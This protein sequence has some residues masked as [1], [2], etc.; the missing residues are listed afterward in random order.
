LSTCS[1]TRRG[2]KE[3]FARSFRSLPRFSLRARPG[4]RFPRTEGQALVEAALA[5]PIVCAFMFTMIEAC[6]AYYS[7]CMI[8]ESAREG[9]R[10][11]IV[12]GAT[13]TTSGNASCT[14]T[15]ASINSYVTSLGWPNLGAGT[16]SASTSFPNSTE[17]PGNP[18]KVTV[19]YVFPI[20]LPFVPRNS[21][22]M[23]S[24]SEMYII[25]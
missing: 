22:S 2:I 11:A 4:S 13:C 5:L 23:S 3:L 21:I 20:N 12:H 9:T 6:L 1:P 17:N 15:T 25:Q 7:Y 16:M 19:T 18:V 14:A 8:S 24:T 10:Y